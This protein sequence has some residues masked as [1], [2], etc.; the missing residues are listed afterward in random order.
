MSQ[1]NIKDL[2]STI[3]E[4]TFKRMEIYDNELQRCHKRIKYNSDLQR[5]YCFF[6]IKEFILGV[7][8]F[9]KEEMKKYIINS[10]TKNG[11]Q[12]LYID[13]NWL[14]ISWYDK[15]S[16]LSI[17]SKHSQKK[18][19]T[20]SSQSPQSTKQFKQIENYQPSGSFIYNDTT[21]KNLSQKLK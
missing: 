6:Q 12:L 1:L 10:L 7:P 3:N 4:K 20:Q 5:T 17:L 9:N 18:Q 8:L 16:E 15:S 2:Y 19:T 13:P 11:F 14:F 21:M